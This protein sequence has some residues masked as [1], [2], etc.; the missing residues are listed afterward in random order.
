MVPLKYS[1]TK[2]ATRYNRKGR[3]SRSPRPLVRFIIDNRPKKARNLKVVR[4]Q[5]VFFFFSSALQVKWEGESGEAIA[6]VNSKV[7]ER[8]YVL[9]ITLYL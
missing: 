7:L 8:F 9:V 6:K 5:V 1:T 4:A 2:C 3:K